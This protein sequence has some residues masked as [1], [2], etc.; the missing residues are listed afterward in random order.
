MARFTFNEKTHFYE[1]DEGL[2]IA[3]IDADIFMQAL[4]ELK[5]TGLTEPETL[6]ELFRIDTWYSKFP[7]P[8]VF[9]DGIEQNA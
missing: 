6:D 4:D 7:C 2:H 5:A 8:G 1:A 3:R 9:I